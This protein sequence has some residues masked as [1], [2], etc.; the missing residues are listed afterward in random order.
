MIV[1]DICGEV[2][3]DLLSAR[4]DLALCKIIPG[5]IIIIKKNKTMLMMIK[6]VS[7]D[8]P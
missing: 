7:E 5:P 2:N 1:T 8:V 6:V 3:G 4:I